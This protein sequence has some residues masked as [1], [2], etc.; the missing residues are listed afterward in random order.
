AQVTR[1]VPDGLGTP[2]RRITLE[3]MF[4]ERSAAPG[5][6]PPDGDVPGQPFDDN[7]APPPTDPPEGPRPDVRPGPEGP[8]GTST[9][10]DDWADNWPDDWPGPGEW[11]D[12]ADPDVSA[13]GHGE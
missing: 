12:P 13:R 9:D 1:T 3:H 7:P 8:A 6:D 2:R 10:D 4:E 5:S 11:D